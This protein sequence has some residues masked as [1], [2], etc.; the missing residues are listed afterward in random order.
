MEILIRPMATLFSHVAFS[1]LS[2]Q[3]AA[4]WAAILVPI[5]C[6]PGRFVPCHVSCIGEPGRA[7][8]CLAAGAVARGATE[9]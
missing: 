5:V 2:A 6:F 3:V 1:L 9:Q 4:Q 8:C 7:G